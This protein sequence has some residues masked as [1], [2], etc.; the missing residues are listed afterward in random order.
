MEALLQHSVKATHLQA[1]ICTEDQA[2]FQGT[3]L[4]FSLRNSENSL[5]AAALTSKAI[6]VNASLVF[7]ALCPML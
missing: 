6:F 4:L 2:V 3:L 7:M 5:K 1:K